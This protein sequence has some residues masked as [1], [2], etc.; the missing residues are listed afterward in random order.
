MSLTTLLKNFMGGL[1]SAV[2]LAGTLQEILTSAVADGVEGG[3]HRLMPIL[4]KNIV[5]GAV[6]VTGVF[7][8]G[9][10]LAKWAETLFATPGAGFMLTGIVLLV[11][12]SL[13]VAY[14]GPPSTR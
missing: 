12:G 1:K 3:I 4:M 7:I 9:L 10:G 8:F 14:R 11:A 6:F 13:Y 5:V 2:S